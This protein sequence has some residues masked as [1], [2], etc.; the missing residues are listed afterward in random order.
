MPPFTRGTLLW[1]VSNGTPSKHTP[2]VFPLSNPARCRHALPYQTL[3]RRLTG[4]LRSREQKRIPTVCSSVGVLSP[5]SSNEGF[6]SSDRKPKVIPLPDPPSKATLGKILPY[7]TKVALTERKL[8]W[9]LAGALLC[10]VVSKVSGLVAPVLLKDAVD[11]LAASNVRLAVGA[12]LLAG[13]Y[14]LLSGVAKE[15]QYPIFTPISQAAARRVAS[16]TF[17]HVLDLDIQFHLDRQSGSLSRILERGT[18]SIQMMFR[19]VVFTFVPTLLELVFVAGYLTHQFS[20]FMAL[21]V[22]ATFVAY[23]AWTLYMTPIAVRVR[24]EANTFDNLTMGKAVDVLQNFETVTLFNN[25]DLEVSQYD[26]YLRGHQIASVETEKVMAATNAGQ[27]IVLSVGLTA[28]LVLSLT[29]TGGHDITAGGLIM[30]QGILL[31]LWLPLQFLGWFYRELRQA[32]I[33]MEDFLNILQTKTTLPDGDLVLPH[34]SETNGN[35]SSST[36]IAGVEVNLRNVFFGYTN[37]RPVLQG[38]SL[39]ID[40]GQSV[41]IVGSSGSGKSTILKLLARLFD[42]TNGVI[43]CDG[44]DIRDLQQ[45]SLRSVIGVVP[46]DT[47]LFN[48]TIMENIRYGCPGSSDEQ[49]I[50]AARMAQLHTAIGRMPTGY[51]T[52]VGER[53]LKLSGGEKQR[54]AIARTFLRAPRLLLCDEA[55]SALDTA[56]EQEIMSSLNRLARG[57]TSVFVAHRLSTIQNCDKIVVMS[58]GKVVEQGTHEELMALERMYYDMWMA[59]ADRKDT[60]NFNSMSLN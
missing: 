7:L 23:V 36:A 16:S 48:E 4:G 26:E 12:V 39:H 28:A 51:Q 1:S 18:R 54:V 37:E 42:V 8:Y 31:Q 3:P 30:V 15:V 49:V 27:H 58:G 41:A 14:R 32:L 46:Q 45:T 57:R 22:T 11:A 35:G 44:I 50:E 38:V 19:V 2:A 55:T 59:Q 34:Q 52:V 20:G 60:S 47:V 29:C 6:G 13:S 56:T 53:G 21:T 17:A 43:Q 9:R 25:K 33:D 5:P 24:K 10:M 40:A